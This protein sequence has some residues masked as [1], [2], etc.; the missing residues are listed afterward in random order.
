[1]KKIPE[2]FRGLKDG[3][4]ICLGYLG[5]SFAFGIFAVKNGLSVIEAA[6]ISMTNLTSAGQ[7]AAVPVIVG[8]GTLVELALGQIVIN[9][10]YMF[11]SVSL[12]QK[13]DK[14][15]KLFDRL[16]IGFANTDEIFAVAT[17]NREDV[18][19]SYMYGLILTPYIGWSFGT[20]LGAV[21]GEFLPHI[22]VSALGIAIYAMFAAI[23]VPKARQDRNMF[24]CVLLA[25]ALSCA[26]YY[27]PGLRNIPQGFAI[28]IC[29]LLAGVI[30]AL[31]APTGGK[32][33]E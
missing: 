23:V 15:V 22:V 10:R 14:N 21:M 18:A 13:L 6:L 9:L 30:F 29:S 3:L 16:V 26:F 28:I 25:I 32:N 33:G 1:M 11:M 8:G 20:V 4:P 27:A 17:S 19:K 5:V 31:A 12:S 7:L 2:F 24:F